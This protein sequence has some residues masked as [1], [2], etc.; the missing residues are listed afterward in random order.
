MV[1]AWVHTCA[2]CIHACL[3]LCVCAPAHVHACLHAC[4]PGWCW[5]FS[6]ST[7]YFIFGGQDLSL[8]PGAYWFVKQYSQW[9]PRICLSTFPLSAVG[10]LVQTAVWLVSSCWGFE[11]ASSC[12]HSKHFTSISN[13]FFLHIL[14]PEY[15]FT[16]L[17]RNLAKTK[18]ETKLSSALYKIPQ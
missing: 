5:V 7:F 1:C 3:C 12:L 6:S 18:Q 13:V 11:L 8:N 16:L 14:I 9:A 2:L 4:S 10:L 15:P 17:G